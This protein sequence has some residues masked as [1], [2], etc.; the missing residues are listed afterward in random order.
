MT[1]KRFKHITN[2]TP[3]VE[4]H[5]L[6]VFIVLKKNDKGGYSLSRKKHLLA[7]DLGAKRGKQSAGTEIN[8]SFY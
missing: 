2:K 5:T 1:L 6:G 8:P 7:R 4:I 3:R